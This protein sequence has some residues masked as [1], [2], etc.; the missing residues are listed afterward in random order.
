MGHVTIVEQ[1]HETAAHA[2]KLRR[3]SFMRGLMGVYGAA[4]LGLGAAFGPYMMAGAIAIS[5]VL[6]IIGW[7][8]LI[9]L[10]NRRV[11]R[12]TMS[13]IALAAVVSGLFGTLLTTTFVAVFAV[14]ACFFA[15]MFRRDGRSHLVE[16][17]AG[18]MMGAVMLVS[19]SLWI[20][21]ARDD[22][23]TDLVIVAAITLA[24]VSMVHGFDT[25]PARYV[26]FING[27]VFGVGLAI[28]VDLSPLAGGL[29]GASIAT[30][31][32]IGARFAVDFP[33]P[34]EALPSL[35]RAMTPLLAVGVIGFVVSKVFV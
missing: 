34:T 5:A 35:S 27:L 1:P 24:I 2:A 29:L 32:L 10:D 3:A 12:A 19:G 14:V 18:S 31:Y 8:D 21:V 23:S 13:V 17:L 6:L 11:P 30:V 25:V 20:F 28:I 33:T 26:G 15:E 4:I 22:A 7:P 9:G 16:Q